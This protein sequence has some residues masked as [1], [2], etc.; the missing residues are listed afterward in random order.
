MS[1][2]LLLQQC[3]ACLA[4]LTWIVFV[5]GGRWPYSRYLV[6]F[7]NFGMNRPW[8]EPRFPRTMEFTLSTRILGWFFDTLLMNNKKNSNLEFIINPL[9]KM[10]LAT[11]II[12]KWNYYFFLLNYEPLELY[13]EMCKWRTGLYGK[14]RCTTSIE[15]T[16]NTTY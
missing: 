2:S 1:S 8:I 4:R 15:K 13:S 10:I 16:F 11:F 9:F 12:I 6:G 3:P 14:R 7:L 5:M